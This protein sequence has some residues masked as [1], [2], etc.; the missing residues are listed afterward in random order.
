MRRADGTI[1]LY[2]FVQVNRFVQYECDLKNGYTLAISVGDSVCN[3]ESQ[4]FSSIING[5]LKFCSTWLDTIENFIICLITSCLLQFSW[6]ERHLSYF[7]SKK[8]WLIFEQKNQISLSAFSYL[9]SAL[10]SQAT[11]L[12]KNTFAESILTLIW[13]SYLNVVKVLN[14]EMC[15]VFKR[16]FI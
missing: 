4:C 11:V 16:T 10:L 2:T 13:C 1:K 12:S 5:S 15:Y 14:S 8:P 3:F 9:T 7:M 6:H